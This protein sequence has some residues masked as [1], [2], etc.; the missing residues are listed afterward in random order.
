M[1]ACRRVSCSKSPEQAHTED[2]R[3][4]RLLQPQ[5][6]HSR[7]K[8]PRDTSSKVQRCSRRAWGDGQRF[9]ERDRAVRNGPHDLFTHCPTTSFSSVLVWR[10]ERSIRTW[11]TER[12]TK[13]FRAE[14]SHF[15]WNQS[16]GNSQRWRRDRNSEQYVR[17]VCAYSDVD[18]FLAV[19]DEDGNT[20][21]EA[22]QINTFGDLSNV[23]STSSGFRSRLRTRIS[24][25]QGQ[26]AEEQTTS[27]SPTIL[28][29]RIPIQA[30]IH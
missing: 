30:K 24:T 2:K 19:F 23:S 22:E 20:L 9:R 17:S 26:W 12:F 29:I 11:A 6:R 25:F 3:R 21:K 16:D 28:L 10:A 18:T 13:G 7:G 8:Q 15:D 5:P 14:G 1:R 4:S 27:L